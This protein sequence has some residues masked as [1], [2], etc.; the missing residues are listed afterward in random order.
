M[1]LSCKLILSILMVMVVHAKSIQNN[2]FTKF[3]QYLKI[4]VRDEGE[5]LC[6]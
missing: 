6:R 2:N 3:L 5:F 1:T 4:K